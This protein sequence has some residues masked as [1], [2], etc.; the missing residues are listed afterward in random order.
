M[1]NCIGEEFLCVKRDE[2][3]VRNS[4]VNQ[5]GTAFQMNCAEKRR[6]LAL[7]SV[8]SFVLLWFGVAFVWK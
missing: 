6:K 8:T 5:R 2:K 7:S 3:I 1:W 4:N